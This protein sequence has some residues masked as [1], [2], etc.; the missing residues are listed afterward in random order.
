MEDLYLF[1]M[2]LCPG[3]LTILDVL[4]S[5]AVTKLKSVQGFTKNNREMLREI[6]RLLSSFSDLVK[7]VELVL[8][9]SWRAR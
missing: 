6:F 9:R 7:V 1:S 2:A 4:S 5:S 8:L 3:F